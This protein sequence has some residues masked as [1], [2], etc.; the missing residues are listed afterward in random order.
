MS[1]GQLAP[2]HYHS[3]I[4]NLED[5]SL[6]GAGRNKD[7][8][9][10]VE[11][12]ESTS[13]FVLIFSS[14]VKSASAGNRHS[15][16][17]KHDGSVWAAGHHNDGRL[18]D[19][20]TEKRDPS[21][22]LQMTSRDG[23]MDGCK[24]VCAGVAF[25]MVLKEDGSVWTAGLNEYGQLGDGTKESR[26][27]LKQVLTKDKNVIALAAG[28]G[29]SMALRFDGIA[30]MTGLNANGQLGDGTKKNRKSF[31]EVKARKNIVAIA[32]GYHHSLLLNKGGV[33]Y[34]AGSGTHGQAG[35]KNTNQVSKFTNIQS[36][37]V[38]VAAGAYHSIVLT[39]D[40]DV[41]TTGLN[42]DGQLGTGIGSENKFTFSK[43]HSNAISVAASFSHSM[44][45]AKDGT[46]W[47]TGNN[48]EGQLGV[49]SSNTQ[50]N[51]LVSVV[52]ATTTTTM[53]ATTTTTTTT[54]T[55]IT[56][57]TTAPGKDFARRLILCRLLLMPYF[58]P[59]HNS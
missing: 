53:T 29:H 59:L 36:Q 22:F 39:K 5:G 33:V 15:M 40:G 45:L 52:Y 25:S 14:G 4:V 30:L 10:G 50:Q 47:A 26:T 6:W 20:S 9:L 58:T 19:G 35:K 32:A 28:H 8:S 56:T 13:S 7:G 18:A 37:C 21:R 46:V 34:F 23:P 11:A 27:R 17:L 51:E 57:T 54:A 12:E 38:D 16:V 24:A 1:V 3:L 48:G 43:V 42:K 2:G 41:L 44:V 55:T 31:Q 49:G